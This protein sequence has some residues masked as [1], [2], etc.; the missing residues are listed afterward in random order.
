MHDATPASRTRIAL[1]PCGPHVD[2][3]EL[4]DELAALAASHDHVRL[5]THLY[6]HVDDE[7]CRA[8][9]G[10]T[11]WELLAAHGWA[12]DRTWLAHVVNPPRAEV[13]E[14][15]AAGVSISHLIAPDL[16][17]G[18]GA[19]PVR[20]Y[21]DAGCTVG[22]GTTGSASNDGADLLGDLRLALLAHRTTDPDDPT[23]WLTARE[24][25]RAATRGSADC[26]GRPELG[27]IAVGARADLAAWDLT[28]VDRVGVHD[29]VAGLLLTGL[30]SHASLVVVDGEVL[31][32]HGEPT[33]LDVAAVAARAHAAVPPL[34]P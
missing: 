24:L 29:P 28:T 13:L 34:S 26:L 30:S 5:H 7:V 8:R 22:F 25:L 17:M 32:E 15:V 33:T 27:R 2:Q 19:A 12:Q 1:A 9:H 6:E 23:R 11:P 4:F 20:S 14:M 3:P 18:W 10:C 31:V 16:R 21:L